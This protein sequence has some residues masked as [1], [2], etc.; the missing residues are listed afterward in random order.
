MHGVYEGH[1]AWRV[2]P[3]GI[4]HVL[5]LRSLDGLE[6]V[7]PGRLH[8]VVTGHR[9]ATRFGETRRLATAP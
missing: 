1:T 7:F 6:A 8:E 3:V 2:D 5:G 9:L 4:A